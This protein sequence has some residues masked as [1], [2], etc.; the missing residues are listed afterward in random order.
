MYKKHGRV[1]CCNCCCRNRNR[2]RDYPYVVNPIIFDFSPNVQIEGMNNPMN[3]QNQ[4]K[5]LIEYYKEHLYEGK[6]A[7]EFY[8]QT[9]CLICMED[10]KF[11]DEKTLVFLDCN[12]FI[13]F[14]CFEKCLNNSIDNKC[15]FCKKDLKCEENKPKTFAFIEEDRIGETEMELKGPENINKADV[16]ENQPKEENKSNIDNKTEDNN[17]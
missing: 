2:R 6:I 17:K 14:T 13:H 15:P 3:I 12:V 11:D 8:A 7:M 16:D 9:E 4:K 5:N 1:C 10:F